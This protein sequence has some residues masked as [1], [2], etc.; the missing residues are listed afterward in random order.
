M[1]GGEDSVDEE[2]AQ[3][4][5]QTDPGTRVEDG[6]DTSGAALEDAIVS[7]LRDIDA[8]ETATMLSLRDE[9]LAALVCRLKETGELAEVGAALREELGRDSAPDDIDRSELLRLALI[10]GLEQAASDV[11]ETA[12]GAYGRY[13]AEGF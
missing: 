9:R 7:A 4:R 6:D 12:R 13:A 11:T 2:L 10:L 5:E 8:G 3:L 1:S